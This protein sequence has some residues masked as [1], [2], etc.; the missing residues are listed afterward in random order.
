VIAALT[1]A[2]AA[3]PAAAGPGV[4]PILFAGG[5]AA[6]TTGPSRDILVRGAALSRGAAGSVFGFVYSGFDLGSSVAPVLFGAIMDHH[7]P[8]AVFLVIAAAYLLGV[9]TVMQ[10]R[11]RAVASRP[12]AGD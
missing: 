11:S 6:G 10:V 12:A 3:L 5:L 7:A 2:V 9:P 4:A 1:F 8:H